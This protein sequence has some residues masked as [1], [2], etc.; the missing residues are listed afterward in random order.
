MSVAHFCSSATETGVNHDRIC[1]TQPTSAT[2][3]RQMVLSFSAVSEETASDC[4]CKFPYCRTLPIFN[5]YICCSVIERLIR[6]VPI[7]F[8]FFKEGESNDRYNEWP[9]RLNIFW[10]Q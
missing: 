3:Q 7:K 2:I 5:G 6:W 10:G 1:N 4:T 8:N 9:H